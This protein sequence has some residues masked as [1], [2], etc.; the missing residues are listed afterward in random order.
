MA[1][2]VSA[3]TAQKSKPTPKATPMATEVKKVKKKANVKVETPEFP[4]WLK[5]S[6]T[7]YAVGTEDYRKLVEK[8]NELMNT[9]WNPW[10]VKPA[11]L[12]GIFETVTNHYKGKK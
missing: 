10:R 4:S 12:Y 2:K 11:I 6:P 7:E 3:K 9:S 1:K 5:S 8:G